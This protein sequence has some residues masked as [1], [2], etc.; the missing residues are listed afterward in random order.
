MLYFHASISINK[1]QVI[2][3]SFRVLYG[4][5]IKRKFRWASKVRQKDFS[6]NKYHRI[7][8]NLLLSMPPAS[9]NSTP[10]SSKSPLLPPASPDDELEIFAP[11]SP[12]PSLVFCSFNHSAHWAMGESF[13]HCIHKLSTPPGLTNLKQKRKQW[14]SILNTFTFLR[15]RIYFS[16]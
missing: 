11:S 8:L 5:V 16:I 9:G 7:S 10:V 2:W 4:Q 15:R 1:N 14:T 3:T 6:M 13:L 12:P